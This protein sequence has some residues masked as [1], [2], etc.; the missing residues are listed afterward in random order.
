MQEQKPQPQDEPDEFGGGT[1]E[2][3]KPPKP[4][5]PEEE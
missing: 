3:P 4:P 2:P 1:G 5:K